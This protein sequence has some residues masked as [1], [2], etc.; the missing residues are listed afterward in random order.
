MLEKSIIC[1]KQNKHIKLTN[2][3][4]T[5]VECMDL[6]PPWLPK[7]CLTVNGHGP[8]EA[9]LFQFLQAF[10]EAPD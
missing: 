10:P 6:G 3:Q 9:S 7:N 4:T 5:D 8:D 1:K 2:T